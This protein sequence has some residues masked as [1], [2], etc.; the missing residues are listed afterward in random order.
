[1]QATFGPT[2]SGLSELAGITHE[3]WVHRQ[4]ELLVELHRA[5]E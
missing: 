1:M 5:K 2:H 3:L 4:M